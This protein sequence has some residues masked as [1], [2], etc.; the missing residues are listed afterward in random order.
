MNVKITGTGS[1][2]P[3]GVEKNQDFHQHEFLNT[4]GSKIDYPNKIIVENLKP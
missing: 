1:Y 3:R 2:I 4:D